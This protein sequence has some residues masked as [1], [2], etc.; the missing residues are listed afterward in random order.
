MKQELP[1]FGEQTFRAW[2]R[3]RS[4]AGDGQRGPVLLWVESFNDHFT[5]D[6]LRSA[7]TVP[8]NAG[9]SVSGCR[10]GTS[11]AG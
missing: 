11:A 1:R 6:V 3:T 9:S 7:V 2:F 10:A 4:P 8:E 5:P